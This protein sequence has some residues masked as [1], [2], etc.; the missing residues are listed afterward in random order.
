MK[1]LIIIRGIN[2]KILLKMGLIAS[3]TISFPPKVSASI[4]VQ[5]KIKIIKIILIGHKRIIHLSTLV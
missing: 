3:I 4:F 1:I 5:K 2:P